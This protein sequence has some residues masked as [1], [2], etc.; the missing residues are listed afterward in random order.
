MNKRIKSAEYLSDFESIFKCPICDSPMK[1]F[2]SKSLIC[3]NN[4][5]FDFTK[6]GYINLTTHPIKTKYSKELFEARRKH[7]AEDG[8]FEPLSQAIA[9]IINKHVAIKKG[10][11]SLIDMGCGEGS[12]L[13]NICDIVSS[14]YK[15]TVTGVGIDISK[16][17]ILVASKNYTNKIWAV[18]DLAN[19]PFKDKQFNVILN[20]LSP[21]N[22]A[23]FNRLLLKRIKR[24]NFR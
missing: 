7:I 19:T 2:E 1:V 23:E 20:I 9:E 24:S 13:S 18:A 21:S 11:I 10:T 5:T 6:Q 14:D 15:K 3:S 12:H 16:E 4:H 22:Y 8:F 17:G